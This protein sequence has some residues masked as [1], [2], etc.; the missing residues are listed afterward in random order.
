[1]RDQQR[2]ALRVF[3]IG[4]VPGHASE[5]RSE[6]QT[7][8]VRVCHEIGRELARAGHEILLCSP[9]E[10]AADIYVLRGAAEAGSVLDNRV[11]FFFIDTPA[12]RARLEAEVTALGLSRVVKVPHPPPQTEENQERRYAWLLCQLNAM[13]SA[14]VV[15]SVGGNPH[16]AANM[17][18]LLAEGKQKATLPLPFLGGAAKLAFDRRRY[19]LKDRLGE[20]ADELQDENCIAKLP[21]LLEAVT[22]RRGAGVTIASGSPLFFISYAKDRQGEADF[23][24]TLLRRRNQRVF[25]DES[26][27]G[28]GHAIPAS[29]REAIFESDVF[30]ALWSSAYACSPWCFDEL[31]LALDRHA[32]GRLELWILRIDSTRMVPKRARDLLFYDALS[33]VE[34]EA[35]ILQLLAQLGPRGAT[36]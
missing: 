19:E 18:L 27:F 21:E 29:I 11:R 4:G 10:D 3:I 5:S 16:G 33:R 25:R 26:D 14:H 6:G 22:G 32:Q 28:A 31:D 20:A 13:E 23:V 7:A 1:M 15:I 34:I 30:I 9:F 17:L 8:L 24:E 35:R 12:V 36:R 2:S